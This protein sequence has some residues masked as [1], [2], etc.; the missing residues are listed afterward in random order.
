MK[1]LF[2]LTIIAII[3]ISLGTYA[4]GEDKTNTKEKKRDTKSIE[5][6][7]KLF[8]DQKK[9]VGKDYA[10]QSTAGVEGAGK[11][12]LKN[13]EGNENIY[14]VKDNLYNDSI[15]TINN[16]VGSE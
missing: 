12:G 11:E 10:A 9:D 1:R 15:K 16:I 6:Y 2:S 14:T 7:R 3:I 4:M 5:R 13:S 8:G